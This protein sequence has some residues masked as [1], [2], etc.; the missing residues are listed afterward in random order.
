M[1]LSFNL[2][3]FVG[4]VANYSAFCFDGW[5]LFLSLMVGYRDADKISKS[6]RVPKNNPQTIP[7]VAR[8][9]CNHKTA[10][11]RERIEPE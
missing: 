2:V 6:S 7:G 1:I 4:E 10:H 3:G 11:M 5:I 9:Y 8:K